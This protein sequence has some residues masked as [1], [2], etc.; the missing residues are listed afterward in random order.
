MIS[1]IKKKYKAYFR[2]VTKETKEEFKNSKC[3][4]PISV[5]Q[6]IHEGEKFCTALDLINRHFKECV[7]LVNDS[8]QWYTH[9]ITNTTNTE[10]ELYD[11]ALKEGDFWIERNK[12]YIQNRLQIPYKLLRWDYWMAQKE[13]Y[14]C[15]DKLSKCY[16]NDVDYKKSI[17]E[18]IEEFLLRVKKRNVE[19]D[20]DRAQSLC[21]RYLL[22]ECA[23]MILWI[24]EKCHFQ[25]YPQRINQSMKATYEKFIKPQYPT[26]LRESPY[27]VR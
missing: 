15:L 25:L 22:E 10:K 13:F 4:V 27:R 3:V 8:V 1:E 21:L 19:V 7:I 2:H 12:G 17:D 9:A 14:P 24:E 5:G 16:H 26:L 11:N 18:N 20:Y 6:I 23:S